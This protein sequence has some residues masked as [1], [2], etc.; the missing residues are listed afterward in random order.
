[1]N[2]QLKEKAIDIHGKKYVLVSDRVLCFNNDYPN[3]KIE[4]KLISDTDN[5]VVIK[6]II[7]P[8]CTK[9]E[10]YFTGISASNPSKTIEA[11]VPHEVA[12]TSA[13]GRALGFMGIGVIDSIASVDE[14]KKANAIPRASSE[15]TEHIIEPI[16]CT[17]DH[18]KLPIMTVLKEGANKGKHYTMCPK[19]K[20]F[21]WV[22]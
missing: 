14:M 21:H 9:P 5:R 22:T 1:M 17:V 20:K 16:E 8:D 7:T 19:C 11:Q 18:D 12:E 3:G 4:T 2:K 15:V 13:V 6:A 10:R